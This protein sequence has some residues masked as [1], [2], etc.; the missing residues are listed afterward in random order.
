MFILSI[1][2]SLD[3]D[4]IIFFFSIFNETKWSKQ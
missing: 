2:A 1:I 4:S 3:L